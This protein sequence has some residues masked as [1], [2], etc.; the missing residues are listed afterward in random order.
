M[1]EM[2]LETLDPAC[3]FP[4]TSSNRIPSS[5]PTLDEPQAG[6]L[7]VGRAVA[8]QTTETI[9]PSDIPELSLSLCL[10]RSRMFAAFK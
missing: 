3:A 5:D 7:P 9:L 4:V 1:G 10:I 2:V 8:L 6:S